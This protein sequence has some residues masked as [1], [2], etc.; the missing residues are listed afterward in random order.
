MQ[1]LRTV[2][3]LYSQYTG[4]TASHADLLARACAADLDVIITTDRNL[5]VSGLDGYTQENNK[6]CLLLTAEEVFDRTIQPARGRLLVMDAKTEL[7]PYAA[8]PQ[9]VV[10]KTAENDSLTFLS[11]PFAVS[12]TA[13][14]E[15]LP[16]WTAEDIPAGISGLE[17]W[18]SLSE[19]QGKASHRFLASLLSW[20]PRLARRGPC[21][22]ACQ[23]WDA[24]LAAGEKLT[25]IAGSGLGGLPHARPRLQH[26]LLTNL[27]NHLIVPRPLSDNL[28]EDRRMVFD[29]LRQ[30]HTY[31]ACD[32]LAPAE[33]FRFTAKGRD[34]KAA[35]GDTVILKDSVTFQIRLPQAATCL[36]YRDGELIQK[37][38][39]TEICVLNSTQPGAYRVEALLTWLD[40]D[41]TWIL[42]NPIYVRPYI[43]PPLRDQLYETY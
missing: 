8:K 24:Q 39:D 12:Q 27:S 14:G 13:L 35:I 16:P 11:H 6:T 40:Q 7:A 34:E 32:D 23:Y 26:Y 4:G 22:Q 9:Q 25:A 30:G 43:P 31:I 38:E 1:E 18:N 33:G 10:K 37:W 28:D 17:V 42:S 3:H 36:L 15:L 41:V 2:L 29:A 5:L 20:F 21:P 19:L